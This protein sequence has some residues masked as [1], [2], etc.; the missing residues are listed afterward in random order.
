MEFQAYTILEHPEWA[1]IQAKAPDSQQRTPVHLC[2]IIDTS[3][4]MKSEQKLENVK[5]SL[6]F[7]L[8]FLR[9]NDKI[10]IVT[11]SDHATTILK[12]VPVSSAEKENIRSRISLISIESNTNLSAGIVCVRDCL[13]NEVDTMK[14]GILLLT[15]GVANLGLTHSPHLVELMNKTIRQFPGTSVSCIGYGSDHNVSLLQ[16]MSAVGGGSYYVVNNLEDV[17]TVFG[18]IL[19]GLVSCTYQHIRVIFP[20][21]TEMKTRYAVQKTDTQTEVIIG[22]LPAGIQAV[23]LAKIGCHETV[24]L[25]GFSLS[26]H[27]DFE[28]ATRVQSTNDIEM[29]TNGEAH[30]LRFEV[31]ALIDTSRIYMNPY[32][33]EEDVAIILSKLKTQID[34]IEQYKK[35][36]AHSLWDVLIHELKQ[37]KR[38]I[39]N[40]RHITPDTP[41]IMSQ[42]TSIL[43]RMRGISASTEQDQDLPHAVPLA[44]FSNRIQRQISA[45]LNSSL[46]QM[47]V[48]DDQEEPGA[49]ASAAAG[50]GA[51]AAVALEP[52][53]MAP[54][55]LRLAR[56]RPSMA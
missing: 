56:N 51:G 4:S 37:C 50:A 48:V 12:Q 38:Y 39:Q 30:Y 52:G 1:C 45:E 27:Y 20:P 35:K 43:G 40:R 42:H 8:D 32:S 9:P 44:I 28:L 53:V 21:N 3:A 17:A 15:D 26:S 13:L 7:L 25:K 55:I 23:F 29:Q 47:D 22:D 11:F 41:Y 33:H 46:S 14:Q 16:D 19:G 34:I 6:Q 10:S 49:E 54:P 24:V 36:N 5:H 31:L 2:C 18:D